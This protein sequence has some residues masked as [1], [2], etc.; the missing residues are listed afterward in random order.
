MTGQDWHSTQ[1]LKSCI[2]VTQSLKKPVSAEADRISPGSFPGISGT[3]RL[4]YVC[5]VAQASVAS[6]TKWGV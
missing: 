4:P 1:L 6:P 5:P 3:G 2:Q